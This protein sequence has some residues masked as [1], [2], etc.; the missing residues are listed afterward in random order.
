VQIKLVDPLAFLL[1]P[2]CIFTWS[3]LIFQPENLLLT[4]DGHIKIADFGSV[5]PTR[6]TPIKVLPNSTSKTKAITPLDRL[7]IQ[8]VAFVK[9]CFSYIHRTDERACTFVGTAAYVPP[10]VLNSAPATFG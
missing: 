1:M 2:Y 8:N 4:S 7:C 6:D 10:E 5:K 9:S 3:V